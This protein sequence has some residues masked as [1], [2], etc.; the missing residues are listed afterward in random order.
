MAVVSEDDN[1][2]K[3]K[4]IDDISEAQQKL[5]EEAQSKLDEVWM[6]ILET[7][8][9]LCPIDTGTLVQTIR[10]E[11]GSGVTSEEGAFVESYSTPTGAGGSDKSIIIY[12]STITAGDE[13][14]INPRTGQPCIYASW[15]HDGHYDRAGK[16]VEGIPFL[17][18]AIEEHSA[19]LDEAMNA[20][21]DAI[22]AE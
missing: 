9:M 18:E 19:E 4:V 7:A 11:Q 8:I 21:F 5:I 12:D 17:E 13:T 22:G 1:G 10:L 2:T 16:W 6:K 14:V 15:V 3:K 20:M